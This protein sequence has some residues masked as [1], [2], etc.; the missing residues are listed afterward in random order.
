M[1]DGVKRQKIASIKPKN[2]ASLCQGTFVSLSFA[3]W[4]SASNVGHFNFIM[5]WGWASIYFQTTLLQNK[6]TLNIST[7][8]TTLSY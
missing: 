5:S 4:D 1:V 2:G 8:A 7:Q 3:G 6:I